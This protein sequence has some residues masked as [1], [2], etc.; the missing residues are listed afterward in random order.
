MYRV[1]DTG[2][3]TISNIENEFVEDAAIDFVGEGKVIRPGATPGL[4]HTPLLTWLDRT[5]MPPW[6][7]GLGCFITMT[8]LA[9]AMLIIVRLP[10]PNTYKNSVA[11]I[12]LISFFLIF[13]FRMGRGWYSDL[14]RFLEF[15]DSLRS[16]L[17]LLEPGRKI[18]VLEILVAGIS[19]FVAM[20]LDDL[21]ED[22][23]LL[24]WATA[25]LFF[26][27]E[28]ATIIF[29]VDIVIRQL[30]ALNQIAK[31]IRIDLLETEF[32][33][34]LANVMIRFVGLYILGLC[35]ITMNLLVFTE[36]EIGGTQILIQ[37]MPWYL[38]GLLLMSLY[39]IP[40][41][42]F[43][44]RIGVLKALELNRISEALK[45]NYELMK[46]SLVADDVSRLTR[47]DLMYYQSLIRG[48]REW[49]FTTRLRS[50]VLFGILPPLTWVIAAF[51]EIMIEGAL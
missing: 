38:P 33:S 50:L 15:D 17:R 12:A 8:L 16:T 25:S 29:C 21:S 18:V 32:Y 11:F 43:R 40:Y 28:W 31:I 13:Y 41:N 23:P 5:G 22:R 39:M 1:S 46:H 45:G 49:P 3:F 6:F 19:A 51:I 14:L 20:T 24:F 34:T 48:V 7:L 27:L 36:G 35:V 47:I 44:K 37:L 2:V 42:I 9:F 10:D 4:T 30:V 26:F